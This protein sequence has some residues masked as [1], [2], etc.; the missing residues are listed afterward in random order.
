MYANEVTVRRPVL[1]WLHVQRTAGCWEWTGTRDQRGYG[2]HAETQAGVKK[3][4]R[5]HRVA[6]TLLVGPIPDG[7]TLD[8]L[9]RNTSC[10]NPDHLEAVSA[11]ENNSRRYPRSVPLSNDELAARYAEGASLAS[12]A[13]L[14]GLSRQG[15][16]HAIRS[17]GAQLRRSGRP[18]CT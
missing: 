16:G 3:R 7:L 8:H 18:S 12:L 4:W 9:C 5:A 11:A 15:V 13:A 2:L 14:V 10:V 1:F 6:Y 17:T